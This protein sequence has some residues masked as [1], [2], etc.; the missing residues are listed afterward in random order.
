MARP[1]KNVVASHNKR[2]AADPTHPILWR[3]KGRSWSRVGGV[4]RCFVHLKTSSACREIRIVRWRRSAHGAKD[5]MVKLERSRIQAF[6][7]YISCAERKG[8]ISFI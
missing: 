1:A 2:G 8:V 5:W 4:A 6:A 3:S 7:G